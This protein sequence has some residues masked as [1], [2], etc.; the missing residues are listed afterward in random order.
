MILP[1]ARFS[2]TSISFAVRAVR[3]VAFGSLVLAVS[4]CERAPDAPERVGP[5]APAAPSTASTASTALTSKYRETPEERATALAL[6]QALADARTHDDMARFSDVEQRAASALQQHA[7]S[8]AIVHVRV[9]ALLALGRANDA[10]ADARA[11]ATSDANDAV[12]AGLHADAL[13]GTGDISGAVEAVEHMMELSPGLPAYARAAQL[14]FATGDVEG[15]LEMWREAFLTGHKS[16]PEGLAFC[17]TG[18][19]DALLYGNGDLAGAKKAYDSALQALPAYPAA[20]LGR[21]RVHIA[22]GHVDLAL[23]DLD[24]IEAH[25]RTAESEALRASARGRSPTLNDIVAVADRDGTQAAL[26]L[27]IHGLD[28]AKAR[29]LLDARLKD[30]AA[31]FDVA[32]L[33]FVASDAAL[34]KKATAS[35]TAD[36]RVLALA[37]LALQS[38]SPQEA[39]AL[40]SRVKP[41]GLDVAVAARVQAALGGAR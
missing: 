8:R 27:F 11:L 21:A 40:L 20:R 4:A 13:L 39:R 34:A 25:A 9:A 36:A 16:Q 28:A 15:S 32:A 35:G 33:A 18:S 5:A 38:S 19:G 41:A 3:A 7:G 6:Q 30:G 1:S 2:R 26:A 37:G 14:R 22:E 24:A 23:A 12:A 31:L 29:A 10:L 17:A